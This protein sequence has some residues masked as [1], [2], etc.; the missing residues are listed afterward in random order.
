MKIFMHTYFHLFVSLNLQIHRCKK[1]YIKMY[2]YIYRDENVFIYIL[3]S[4]IYMRILF[5][6]P[7]CIHTYTYTYLHY[8]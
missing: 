8:I 2:K 1:V 6:L 4:I 5:F 3:S 7:F